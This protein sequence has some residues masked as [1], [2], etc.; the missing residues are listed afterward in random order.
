MFC[1]FMEE[2][3]PAI[4]KIAWLSENNFV[5]VSCGTFRSCR[6]YRNHVSSKHV[7]VLA[8]NFAFANDLETFYCFPDFHE[9][10]EFPRKIQYI[11][12]DFFVALQ[13]PQ[14]ISEKAFKCRSHWVE[15]IN[16]PWLLVP[17]IYLRTR[18]TT[19]HWGFRGCMFDLVYVQNK[20]C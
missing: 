5:G 4:C 6:I 11:V 12:I 8:R 13:L 15:Y 2:R 14:Y 20:L 1:T 3:I 7:L 16:M 9:T 19:S 18:I 17:L 10:R